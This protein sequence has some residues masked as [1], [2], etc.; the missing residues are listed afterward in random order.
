MLNTLFCESTSTSS[1][2]ENQPLSVSIIIPAWP[3]EG[4]TF[5]LDWIEKL[6][7]PDDR[8]EVLIAR[9][10]SP[11]RQRNLAAQEAGSDNRKAVAKRFFGA[12]VVSRP[13]G[14]EACGRK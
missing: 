5:G 4:R 8:L 12:G 13:A 11:C 14:G 7:Y 9:G 10:Y 6:S 3:Q 1:V 2:L